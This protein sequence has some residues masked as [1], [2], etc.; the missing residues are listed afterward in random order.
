MDDT[1]YM[2]ELELQNQRRM[3]RTSGFKNG[4]FI[5]EALILLIFLV[6]SIAVFTQLFAWSASQSTKS[7][8]LQQA[9]LAATNTA[10]EFANDPTGVDELTTEGDLDVVCDVTPSDMPNGTLYSAHITVDKDGEEL[11]SLDTKRYVRGV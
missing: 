6:L 11:Y 3:H 10:E 5:I 2:D 9:V 8:D 7:Y 4:A 1:Q